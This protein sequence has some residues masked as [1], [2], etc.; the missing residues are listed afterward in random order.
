LSEHSL[1]PHIQA[2]THHLYLF[3]YYARV[4]H[5]EEHTVAEQKKYLG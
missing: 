5:N 3:I 2:H 4:Q 1:V